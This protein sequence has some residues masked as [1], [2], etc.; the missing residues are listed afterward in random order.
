MLQVGCE[1]L[2]AALGCE[3]VAFSRDRDQG[4]P[5]RRAAAQPAAARLEPNDLA[6]ADWVAGRAQ[7]AGRFTGTLSGSPWWFMP[8]VV[9]RGLPG[10]RRAAVSARRG[11]ARA[12]SSACSPRRWSS[13]SRSPPSAPGWSPT[14]RRA[15][16]EGE[17][18]RLRAA[19]LSSVSHD[20]RSPLASVIGAATS[21]SA[22]G[23]TMPEDD[24]RRAPGVDPQRG[25]AARPLH[26]EPARHDPP[27]RGRPQAPARLGRP[28][29]DPGLGARRACASSTP[30]SRST[31][32]APPDLPPAPRPSG[33][34]RAGA[35]Q[36]PRERRQVLAAGRRR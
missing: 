33:A 20:L 34:D 23:E 7:P 6:A 10:R 13:R 24:R 15:R 11:R 25:R 28:R 17:T 29:R 32:G 27:G 35:L 19:L 30:R 9:E 31:T 16:V 14:S 5:L 21:L 3:A 22:Y 4:G 1:A 12:P 8:L 2:A 26:P 36:H 18:E